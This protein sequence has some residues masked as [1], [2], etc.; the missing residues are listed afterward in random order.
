MKY[1]IY[2]LAQ[3]KYDC[4]AEVERIK[5]LPNSNKDKFIQMC[6]RKIDELREAISILSERK[7]L[8][9]LIDSLNTDDPKEMRDIKE[10]FSFD[11]NEKDDDGKLEPLSIFQ[12]NPEVTKIILK[13]VADEIRKG[14]DS[15]TASN[16]LFWTLDKTPELDLSDINIIADEVE[17]GK[18]YGNVRGLWTFTIV[19]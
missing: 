9:T 14:Y 17:N 16:N 15:G 13:E 5:K 2:L 18:E 7:D 6:Q 8:N 10:G 1:A 12:I 4:E 11:L 19:E 3:E